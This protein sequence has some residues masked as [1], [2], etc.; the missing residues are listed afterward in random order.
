MKQLYRR[1]KDRLYK[2]WLKY[3]PLFYVYFA[4]IILLIVSIIYRDSYTNMV[5]K[6]WDLGEGFVLSWQSSLFQDLLFFGFTGF[7]SMIIT[8]REPHQENFDTRVHAIANALNVGSRTKDFIKREIEDLMVFNEKTTVNLTIENAYPDKNLLELYYE[9][10]TIKSNMCSDV[11]Q[12]AKLRT[13]IVPGPDYH[14][15]YGYLKVLTYQYMKDESKRIDVHTGSVYKFSPKG[16]L[17]KRTV[18]IEPHGSI[19]QTLAYNLYCPFNGSKDNMQDVFFT[20]DL[21]FTEKF[22]LTLKNK[23]N[24]TIKFD[25]SYPNRAQPKSKN[26]QLPPSITG[27]GQIEPGSQNNRKKDATI[28]VSDKYLS[29]SDQFQIFFYT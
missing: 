16:F 4:F 24:S 7:L 12:D 26:H 3:R 28:V 5:E 20:G 11:P 6:E 27:S 9:R 14:G 13:N 2:V 18:P 21:L 23:T 15:D 8:T 29:K 22:T 19:L 17:D 10:T 1:I 25:F